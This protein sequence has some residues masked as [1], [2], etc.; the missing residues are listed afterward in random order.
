MRLH[1][2][3]K[4]GKTFVSPGPEEKECGR[5]QAVG[6]GNCRL[7]KLKKGEAYARRR[8]DGQKVTIKRCESENKNC[9]LA[10]AS[11]NLSSTVTEKSWM[12]IWEELGG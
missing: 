4:L 10:S 5:K 9:R 11:K 7:R 1:P 12:D 8:D 6:C 3:G 2:N